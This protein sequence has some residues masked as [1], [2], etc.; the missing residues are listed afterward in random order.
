MDHSFWPKN[1]KKMLNFFEKF[2]DETV[3]EGKTCSRAFRFEK[4]LLL[5]NATP[6]VAQEVRF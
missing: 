1:E 3:L 5:A 4:S 2:V 6:E